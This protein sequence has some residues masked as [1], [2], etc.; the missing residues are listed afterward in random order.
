MKIRSCFACNQ[1]IENPLSAENTR[2][3]LLE[4]NFPNP[5]QGF[6]QNL[7]IQK[8]LFFLFTV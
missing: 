3:P 7:Y 1:L 5:D 8:M 2:E 4:T 6:S